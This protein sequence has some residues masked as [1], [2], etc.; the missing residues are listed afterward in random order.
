VV[1]LQEP[2][3]SVFPAASLML[4]GV[5]AARVTFGFSVATQVEAL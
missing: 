4:E 5:L 1:K 3:A 2:P